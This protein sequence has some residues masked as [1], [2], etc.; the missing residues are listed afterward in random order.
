MRPRFGVD[1]IWKV[2]NTQVKPEG[3]ELQKCF[4]Y[5]LPKAHVIFAE[6]LIGQNIR[7]LFDFLLLATSS[8]SETNAAFNVQ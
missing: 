1:N 8:R 4:C 2:F 3:Q 6:W 7:R 5:V